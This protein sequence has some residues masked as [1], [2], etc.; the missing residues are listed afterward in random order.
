MGIIQGAM[1]LRVSMA[2]SFT[3]FQNPI[4]KNNRL[5]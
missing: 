4:L 2:F 3:N 5:T 1:V